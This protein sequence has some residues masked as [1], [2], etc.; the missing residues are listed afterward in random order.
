MNNIS[1][2]V[3]ISGMPEVQKKVREIIT[4]NKK[5]K[6][7]FIAVGVDVQKEIKSVWRASGA[8]PWAPRKDKTKNHPL[9]I[10]TG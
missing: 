6:P 8:P 10:L 5:M 4:A 3:D 9:L 2:R 7:Y 1:F